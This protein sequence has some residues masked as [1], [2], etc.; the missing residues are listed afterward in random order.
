MG[1]RENHTKERERNV[2]GEKS[3][4]KT[5]ER[6]R[7]RRNYSE[8]KKKLKKKGREICWKIVKRKKIKH[9]K[10]EEKF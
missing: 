4:G 8:R 7:N 9:R 10:S 2:S 5:L 3:F 1:E 6:G